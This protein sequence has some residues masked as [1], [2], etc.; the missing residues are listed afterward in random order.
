MGGMPGTAFDAPR[1]ALLLPCQR[2]I[3]P[4]SIRRLAASWPVADRNAPVAQL[5]RA[6]DFGS[7]GWG[8]DSLRVYWH[9]PS[10]VDVTSTPSGDGFERVSQ[11]VSRAGDSRFRGPF[12][13]FRVPSRW[14]PIPECLRRGRR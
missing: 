4:A 13:G 3:I 1:T 2:A 8:F 9:S 6:T 14:E 12:H 5:D 10:G 11:I 7:V